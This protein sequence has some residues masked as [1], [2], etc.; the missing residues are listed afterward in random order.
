MRLRQH[1][2]AVADQA[3]ELKRVMGLLQRFEKALLLQARLVTA[4]NRGVGGGDKENGVSSLP[5]SALLS[6]GPPA[7]I[8]D[9]AFAVALESELNDLIRSLDTRM[10]AMTDLQAV[11]QHQTTASFMPPPPPLQLTLGSVTSAAGTSNT[12]TAMMISGV[13]TLCKGASS[14]DQPPPPPLHPLQFKP[15]I[16][17]LPPK[18]TPT[19][20]PSFSSSKEL[21]A[22]GSISSGDLVSGGNRNSNAKRG[23][24][25]LTRSLAVNAASSS[26]GADTDMVVALEE[27]K[28]LESV[29]RSYTQWPP[30]SSPPPPVSRLGRTA[31]VSKDQVNGASSADSPSVPIVFGPPKSALQKLR[32]SVG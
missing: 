24:G 15:I 5:S 6:Y 3:V 17:D 20:P 8:Q 19:S 21:I 2:G 27:L 13:S 12:N 16:K 1:E 18:K 4:S 22:F 23:L 9:A 31:L 7:T 29:R 14:S 25:S 10:A 30:T 28:R 26:V 11:S 32:D